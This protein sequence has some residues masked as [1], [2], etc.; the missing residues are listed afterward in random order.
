MKNII[1]TISLILVAQLLAVFTFGQVKYVKD[2]VSLL[3]TGTSTLHDWEM[4]STGGNCEATFTFGA[5]GRITGLS[6]LS[7]STQV[8]DLKS[9]K[10]M[11]DKKCYSA[12]KKDKFATITYTANSGTVAT[13]D[14]VNY[15][16]KS[17]GVL[18]IAGVAHNV[19]LISGLRLNAD[20]SISVSGSTHLKMKDFGV[21]P[22]SFL[23][24][25]TGNEITVK[26]DVT[27]KK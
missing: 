6:G 9:G 13:T 4:K 25:T 26:F 24:A 21:E 19:E 2:K 12:L 16:V 15:T 20:K 10:G 5:N 14:G 18:T 11:M 17:V 3:V 8:A 27:L 22:P 1:K 23:F 7:F